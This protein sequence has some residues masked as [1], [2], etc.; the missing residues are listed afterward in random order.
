MA[1]RDQATDQDS[2]ARTDADAAL[3]EGQAAHQEQRQRGHGLRHS[4]GGVTTRDDVLDLGVPM[5]PGD[6]REPVGPEDALGAGPKRGNYVD[7]IGDA[8]YNPHTSEPIP[9]E[10]QV[11]GGPTVRLVPQR[12]R[13]EEIGDEPALKGGV[14][15]DP[16]HPL[17]RGRR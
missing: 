11:P 3:E 7:R 13:A 5:L 8:S 6:P 10:E 17:A 15:T 12:P 4:R 14:E 9:V 2:I 1:R 16:L